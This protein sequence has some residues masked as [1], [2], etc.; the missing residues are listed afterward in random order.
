M[1][2]PITLAPL[3]PRKSLSP[4]EVIHRAHLLERRPRQSAMST[5]IIPPSPPPEGQGPV[6]PRRP[7]MF[8][9]PER[10]SSKWIVKAVMWE[11]GNGGVVV[12]FE[13]GRV[14]KRGDGGGGFRGGVRRDMLKD[15]YL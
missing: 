8:Q 11:L 6:T 15:M 5:P 13:G 9:E 12:E 1:S 14:L 3:P 2:S 7:V 4:A 10:P